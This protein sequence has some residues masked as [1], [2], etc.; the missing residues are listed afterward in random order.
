M[1]RTTL[2]KIFSVTIAFIIF[3]MIDNGLMVIF[4]DAIDNFFI[5]QGIT[6][7]MLAAGFGNTFSDAIGILSGRWVEKL[8]QTKIPPVEDGDLTKSQIILSETIGIIIGCLIGL[9]PLYFLQ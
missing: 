4:G 7:T 6:N 3:G 1:K 5:K 9:I 8:V 2:S